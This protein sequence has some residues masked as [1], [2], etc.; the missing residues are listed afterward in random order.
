MSK[1]KELITVFVLYL[2]RYSHTY[3]YNIDFKGTNQCMCIIISHLLKRS[4]ETQKKKK[5]KTVPTFEI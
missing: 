5:K 1:K 2:I 3:P 4:R